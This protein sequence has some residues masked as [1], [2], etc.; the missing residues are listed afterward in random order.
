[1]HM[2]L[3]T[4]RQGERTKKRGKSRHGRMG[5]IKQK[6]EI[7]K[8]IGEAVDVWDGLLRPFVLF[9]ASFSRSFLLSR[10]SSS[11]IVWLLILSTTLILSLSVLV[12]YSCQAQAYVC[13]VN[14]FLVFF[15]VVGFRLALDAPA[16]DL[17][18]K[19]LGRHG[20]LTQSTVKKKRI[21]S[22]LK[23]KKSPG[24]CKSN[25]L[26]SKN[27]PGSHLQRTLGKCDVRRAADGH[28]V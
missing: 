15:S 27:T 4:K 17:S 13:F 24:R 26:R 16:R 7:R 11:V 21:H 10:A 12:S 20:G 23:N 8:Y 25:K 19:G 28:L 3:S 1:M 5:K 2:V 14:S 9:P 6:E 22:K 18:R